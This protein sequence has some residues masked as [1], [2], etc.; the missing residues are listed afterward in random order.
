MKTAFAVAT[1]ASV[2]CIIL[3]LIAVALIFHD[4]NELNTNVMMEMEEFKMT[5]EDTWREITYVNVNSYDNIKRSLFPYI[6]VFR[7][8]RQ[9]NQCNCGPSPKKCPEGPAGPRGK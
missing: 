8:K 6:S 5:A 2:C 7:A 1:S 4:I 9:N 3:S